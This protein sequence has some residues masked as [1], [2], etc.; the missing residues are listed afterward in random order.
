[1]KTLRVSLTAL[2]VA[3]VASG[4]SASTASELRDALMKSA[5]HRADFSQEF[6]AKGF[7]KPRVETGSVVIGKLPNMRWSYESPEVKT[8]VFDGR[9]SW[10]WAKEDNQVLVHEVGAEESASLPFVFLT[11]TEWLEQNYVISQESRQGSKVVKLA[12]KM[13]GLVSEI[14]IEVDRRSGYVREL[15]WVDDAGNRTRFRLSNYRPVRVAASTFS[16]DPPPGA[17]VVEN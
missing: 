13:R 4:A 10:F 3:F 1:M 8:F 9:T 6:T 12:P 14:E 2:F 5:G 11:N 16:F 17:S 7:S 15:S